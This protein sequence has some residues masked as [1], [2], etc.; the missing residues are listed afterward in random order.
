MV[1]LLMVDKNDIIFSF[2]LSGI[3]RVILFDRQKMLVIQRT[4]AVDANVNRFLEQKNM[5]VIAI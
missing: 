4:V 2:I 3:K 5:P 1:N